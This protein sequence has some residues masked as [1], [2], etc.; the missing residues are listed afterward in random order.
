[1]H[2]SINIHIAL[3]FFPPKKGKRASWEINSAR[4]DELFEENPERFVYTILHFDGGYFQLMRIYFETDRL[5]NLH[6]A[7]VVTLRA[8][9]KATPVLYNYS[10]VAGSPVEV[11]NVRTCTHCMAALLTD[12]MFAG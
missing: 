11:S 3:N 12:S 1:M 8:L 10:Y 2:S 4:Y 6:F 7:F 9:R 5:K